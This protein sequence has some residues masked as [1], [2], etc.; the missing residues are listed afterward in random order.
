MK[1]WYAIVN[2]AAGGGRCRAR[3]DRALAR[4]ER[5]G[6]DVEVQFTEGPRHASELAASA[7]EDGH[8]RF[9]IVGGDGTSYEVVN[10]LFP[11]D[12]D[13][14]I[15]LGMLPLGTGNSFL[16]DYGITSEDA[17]LHALLRGKTKRVDL[18]RGDHADG[19]FHSINIIGIGF[20]ARVGAM[21]NERFKALGGGG[22]VASVL[23][24]T[25]GLGTT[26][27]PLRLDD[28]EID[29]RPAVFLS[30]CNSRYTGGGMQMAPHADA[31]DGLVDV[32]RCGAVS[33][34]SL[35]ATFP[36]IF[37]GT[38]VDHPLVEET[39]AKRVVFESPRAQPV[40]IDGEIEH[41]AMSKLE[42]LPGAVEVVV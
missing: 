13:D 14:P 36:K 4:L 11:R 7:Y 34:P 40:M 22:Y 42:V 21:T 2:G 26:T 25:A 20:T 10:G 28:G 23:L 31:G 5:E 39:R 35:V 33:R 27:D 24:C 18:V 6:I 19:V 38:H 37:A 32:I 41:F 9:L 30:F 8:R 12:T 16:R 17:A 29:P 15:T 1:G 3:A